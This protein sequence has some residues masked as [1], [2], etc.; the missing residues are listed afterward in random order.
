[1]DAK[2]KI[3]SLIKEIQKHNIDY[4]V[5]D[6]PKIS[7]S[8]Y[9]TLIRELENLEKQNPSLISDYSPTKRV[10][11]SPASKFKSINHSVPMLSLA[12][13][14]N[15]EELIEFDDRIKKL[16]NSKDDIEYVM[17][18]KLDGL[19]VEVVYE[20]GIFKHGSTRGDG[21]I[22]EDVSSNLKTIKAIPLKLLESDFD[23]TGIVEFRGE[24]FI[25]HLD[26]KVLNQNRSKN[27]ESIFAN[28]RNCAAGSLRQ[29]NPNITAERPLKIN[30]YS[31]GL[32]GNLEINTQIDL[33]NCLPKL[34]LPV[35]KHIKL[36]RG[37]NDVVSYYDKL[38]SIRGQLNYDIDGVVIKVNSFAS[39]S[40][41]GERSRSPRWAIAGKLKSQQETTTIINI[42]PSVG[43]TGA[44]TPVAKLNPV[45]VG[46]V[47]VSNATLH[48][49]DEIQRKDIRIGD[50]VVIH[51]AGDVIPEVVK[52]IKEKRKADSQ[53]YKLP[54]FC[55]SCKS[56][57]VRELGDAVLRCKNS[58]AC[59]A[60][61]KGRMKHFVSKNCMDID[62]IGD[63]LIESLIENKLI[64]RYS[65]IFNLSYADLENLDRMGEKSINNILDS[66]NKSKKTEFSKFLNG[67]GIRNIGTHACKLLEKKFKSDIN[68]LSVASEKDLN[69]IHEI[70]EIMASSI[71][72]YFSINENI[73]DINRCISLGVNFAN[74]SIS[75][76]LKGISFVITGSFNGISRSE[77][78][79]KIELMGARVSS[80]ISKNTS[81]LVLGSSPGSKLNKAKDLNIPIIME[82]QLGALLD[83]NLSF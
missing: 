48:N 79:E 64:N 40:L 49:Q 30:F 43:R 39:Q 3:L 66:I 74:K 54:I 47:V 23:T 57:A 81:Y 21:L 6:N 75:D 22:G 80:S 28:P 67:L 31:I 61:I 17:E 12:N 24:V 41:I 62:G 65:D 14:M 8:K 10:G 42:I 9:D 76:E 60:Q 82:D 58:T 38:E 15:H 71:I 1:M 36:G 27:N 63:K 18:P 73:D 68:M 52:V 16:L 69:D 11:A 72:D 29:L 26:F 44:I 53:G 45:N 33:I 59:R 35:N 46:G 56:D 83:G 20:D 19:A 55:P 2:E 51:R 77:I 25:D 50:T 78:K 4:Y 7:D 34:G 5:N 13:A 37:I 70:G 32:K